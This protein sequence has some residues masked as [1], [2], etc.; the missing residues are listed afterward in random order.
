VE[1]RSR[2]AEQENIENKVGRSKKSLKTQEKTAINRLQ[3]W[4]AVVQNTSSC[5]Q[6]GWHHQRNTLEQEAKETIKNCSQEVDQSE[7]RVYRLLTRSE[8]KN[9]RTQGLLKK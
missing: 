4:Q 9:G 5:M 3:Q 8:N 7:S 2:V 6:N 1:Q